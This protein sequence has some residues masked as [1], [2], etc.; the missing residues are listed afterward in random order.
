M[1][2]GDFRTGEIIPENLTEEEK[3]RLRALYWTT[4]SAQ[5]PE[6]QAIAGASQQRISG[7]P[8]FP[9][10]IAVPLAAPSGIMDTAPL[11]APSGRMDTVRPDSQRSYREEAPAGTTIFG[12]APV[13]PLAE[14]VF[15]TKGQGQ[16]HGTPGEGTKGVYKEEVDKDKWKDVIAG[17][18]A[19]SEPKDLP[20]PTLN[21][22]QI[23][24]RTV[25]GGGGPMTP[26]NPDNTASTAFK[27]RNI[28]PQIL[29]FLR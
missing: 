1:A 22:N 8:S 9:P 23:P 12:E 4:P 19:L 5:I 21:L 26:F 28:A 17:L 18:A 15:S 24:A 11:A 7:L 2:Y 6:R 13:A 3:E 10:S 27:D 14:G 29:K 25:Q 16:G 20:A